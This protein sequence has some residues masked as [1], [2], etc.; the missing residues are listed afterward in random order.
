MENTEKTELFEK[1]LKDINPDINL[2][3][4]NLLFKAFLDCYS[5]YIKHEYIIACLGL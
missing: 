5:F 1:R 4:F 2:K 3:R